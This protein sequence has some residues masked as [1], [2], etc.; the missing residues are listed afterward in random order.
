VEEMHLQAALGM[1]SMF[2]SHNEVAHAALNRSLAIAKALGNSQQELQLLAP[3]HFFHTRNR[4]FNTALSYATNGVELARSVGDPTV[5][6]L[7]QT[8]RGISLHFTGQLGDARAE[9]ETVLRRE[10]VAPWANPVFLASGHRVWAG[11]A[12]ARTLWLQG[13]PDQARQRA[14][15]TIEEAT[16]SDE[17]LSL[18]LHWGSSV[19]LWAGDVRTKQYVDRYISRVETF[20]MGPNLTIGH[21]IRAAL[22]IQQGDVKYGVEDLQRCLEK[23]HPETYELHTELHLALIQ[24][25]VA[26]GRFAEALRLAEESIAR[27][28]TNGD[29]C[30]M[31][32]L[33]RLKGKALLSSAKS[34]EDG[35]ACYRRSL[36]LSGRQGAMAWELRTSIDLA[37]LNADQGRARDA[38]A[39]LQPVFAR[40]LEGSDTADVKTAQNLLATLS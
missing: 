26:I 11:T 4:E 13:Y 7:A 34:Y 25:F 6:A 18:A 35:E 21:G 12:L 40:F 1:S 31:P 17:S 24:G 27:L 38:R 8:L 15:L 29:F 22:A 16:I 19:F 37:A 28:E 3:L 39:L 14:L 9:L 2:E 33:L 23:L 10:S 32:E 20:S 5:I 36:E 30:F